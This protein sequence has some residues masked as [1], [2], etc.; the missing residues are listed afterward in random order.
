MCCCVGLGAND[1][2]AVGDLARFGDE[3]E[4]VARDDL[5]GLRALPRDPRD[6]H[7]VLD[8]HASGHRDRHDAP[9][10]LRFGG[11][12]AD[13]LDENLSS[14]FDLLAVLHHDVAV[15]SQL[16]EQG[17]EVQFPADELGGPELSLAIVR[18]ARGDEV[19]QQLGGDCPYHHLLDIRHV[20]RADVVEVLGA[21]LDQRLDLP[22]NVGS[23][24]DL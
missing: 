17:A 18:E 20:I 24:L 13:G 4:S 8:G 16:V 2:A 12:L 5:G 6:V 19:S 23:F 3:P 14:E 11:S 22:G 9:Q 1:D 15:G 7:H 21:A 10:H